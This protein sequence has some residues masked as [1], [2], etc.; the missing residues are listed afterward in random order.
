MKETFDEL[1]KTILEINKAN[2]WNC[3]TPSDWSDTY[4]IPAVIGLIHTEPSEALEAFRH[5]DKEN[6][7]EEIADTVIRCFDL[8]YGLEMDLPGAIAAKLEKNRQRGYKHG[9]KRL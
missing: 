1:G 4:K 7:I 2:G 8:A 3:V 9:G 5:N 6:F